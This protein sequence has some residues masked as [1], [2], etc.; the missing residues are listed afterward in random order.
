M[1]LADLKEV[2]PSLARGLEALLAHQGARRPAKRASPLRTPSWPPLPS[3]LGRPRDGHFRGR[4][5]DPEARSGQEGFGGLP[6]APRWRCARGPPG[7]V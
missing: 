6:S 3:Y 2:E 5:A 7:A 4:K 1:G